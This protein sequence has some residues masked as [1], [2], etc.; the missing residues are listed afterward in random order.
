MLMALKA[1]G[2][3]TKTPEL[4]KLCEE[5]QVSSEIIVFTVF[6]LF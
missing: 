1:V 6:I 5:L 3:E 4:T 2:A